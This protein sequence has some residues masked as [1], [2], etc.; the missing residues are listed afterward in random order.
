MGSGLSWLLIGFNKKLMPYGKRG[1]RMKA[2][3]VC[4]EEAGPVLETE[5]TSHAADRISESCKS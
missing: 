4:E 5:A 2:V 3:A 1:E